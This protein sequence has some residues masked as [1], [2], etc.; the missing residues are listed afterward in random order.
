MEE[1]KKYDGDKVR[2]ELLYKDLVEEL[3]GVAKVLTFGSK[4]YGSRNWMNLDNGVERY[5]AA[6]FRH[7]NAFMKGEVKDPESG[8]DHLSHAICCILFSQYIHKKETKYYVGF[9]YG[10]VNTVANIF[11]HPEQL[12]KLSDEEMDGL[13]EENRKRYKLRKANPSNNTLGDA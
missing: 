13:I 9:D 3:E 12:F 5:L 8:E 1:G 4:K 11:E 6:A 2:V 10:A 7:I